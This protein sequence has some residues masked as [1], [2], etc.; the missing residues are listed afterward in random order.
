LIKN[1]FLVYEIV[2]IQNNNII[3]EKTILLIY[4]K[5]LVR[6]RYENF[7]GLLPS[8]IQSHFNLSTLITRKENIFPKK[9]ERG[10]YNFEG[11]KKVSDLES[12]F[13]GHL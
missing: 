5:Y 10:K 1:G 2:F 7:F 11:R 6:D 8:N 4:L 13:Q 3:H 12:V 9:H